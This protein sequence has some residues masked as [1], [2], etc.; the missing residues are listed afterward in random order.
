MLI[1]I[2]NFYPIPIIRLT[3]GNLL[4]NQIIFQEPLKTIIIKKG[5]QVIGYL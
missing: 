2:N 1:S 5:V 4:R 3:I